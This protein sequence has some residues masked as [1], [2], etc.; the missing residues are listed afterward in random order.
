MEFHASEGVEDY[1]FHYS[2]KKIRKMQ[3]E[4]II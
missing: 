4:V 1:L 3:L 2:C